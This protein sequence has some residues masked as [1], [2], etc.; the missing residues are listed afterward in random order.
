VQLQKEYAGR[1]EFAFV[2]IA[3]AHAADE[4]PV[5]SVKYRT[6]QTKTLAARL[7]VAQRARQQLGLTSIPTFVDDP[8][9][10]AFEQLFASWPTRFFLLFDGHMARIENPDPYGAFSLAGII[11]TITQLLAA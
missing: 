5:G 9:T 10:N 11:D 3:E 7:E 6:P 1:V 2:Y 8:A 4:W